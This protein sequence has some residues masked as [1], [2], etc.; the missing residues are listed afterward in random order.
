MNRWGM[1]PADSRERRQLI[2]AWLCDRH[3]RVAADEGV[4]VAASR[5]RK[6]GFPIDL[7]M[8]VLGITPSSGPWPKPPRALPPPR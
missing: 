8:R 3:R 7:T 1:H 2:A 4:L 6:Y 5:L